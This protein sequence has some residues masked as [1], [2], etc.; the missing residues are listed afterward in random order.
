MNL[1][2]MM[3]TE[4]SQSQKLKYFVIPLMR[5]LEE[6]NPQRQKVEWWFLRARSR[7]DWEGGI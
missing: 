4:I 7:E 6:S 1:E 3:L 5:S 2:V